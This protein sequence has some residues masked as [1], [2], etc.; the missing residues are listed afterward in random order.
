[1]VEKTPEQRAEQTFKEQESLYRE[2]GNVTNIW[3]TLEGNLC[4]LFSLLAFGDPL[5]FVA[6][7]IF[8]TPSNTVTRINMVDNLIAYFF[9][10][11]HE[12]ALEWQRVKSK[13]DRLKNTRNAIVHGSVVS[14]GSATQSGSRLTPNFADTLRIARLTVQKGQLCG[15]SPNELKNHAKAVW[16]VNNQVAD[17]TNK[18]REAIKSG[19]TLKH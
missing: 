10:D 13:L 15:L 14:A 4:G 7:V 18:A 16:D 9:A 12:V 2:I 1:M 3:S 19:E 8:F 17:L 11:D 5:R 6:G